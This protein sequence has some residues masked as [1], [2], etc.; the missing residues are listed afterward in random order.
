ME[1]T[2]KRAVVWLADGVEEMEAVIALD[3]LRRGKVEAVGMAIAAERVVK[4]SRGVS[5][6]ADTLWDDAILAA[7]DVLVVPGGM[8]GMQ[9]LRA[10]PR[11]LD[12]LRQAASA[13]RWTAAVCAGP[14][15]LAE[16]GL[17]R[18]RRATCHPSL[19][20]DLSAFTPYCRDR[21]VR[22][23]RIITSQGPGTSMAFAVEILRALFDDAVADSVAQGLLLTP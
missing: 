14:L 2:P 12:R 5:I 19:A 8:G 4:G 1:R 13:G 9:A 15:V 10:D 20:D 6:L 23:G 21:V 22:D 17:L 3:V 11:V 18:G 16:A 7:A